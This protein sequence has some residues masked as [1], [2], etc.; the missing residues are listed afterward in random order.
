LPQAGRLTDRIGDGRLV[1]IGVLTTLLGT[2]AFMCVSDRSSYLLLSIA[3]FVRG[4]GLGATNTPA[5]AAAYRHLTRDELPNATT[6]LNVVQRL[7]APL[8]TATMAVVLQRF[9]SASHAQ[10]APT[11]AHA[12]ANTFM[13]SGALSALAL[14][15]ALSLIRSDPNRRRAT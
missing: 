2:L 6:V 14:F 1:F 12:F 7:G 13:V 3:L 15:A 4:I 8:G 11:L 10:D 5:L 9:M